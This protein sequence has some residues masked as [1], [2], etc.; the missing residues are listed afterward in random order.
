M[1]S[2]AT[3][4][5]AKKSG[6]EEYAH[7]GFWQSRV[8]STGYESSEDYVL[9]YMLDKEPQLSGFVGVGWAYP[10]KPYAGEAH[11]HIKGTV[12]EGMMYN[13]Q[14]CVKATKVCSHWKAVSR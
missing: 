9:K 7:C 8:S 2:C 13:D 5:Y 14:I 6:N 1:E 3:C 12:T 4:A 11:W 10:N